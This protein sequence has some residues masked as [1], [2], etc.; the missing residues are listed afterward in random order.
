MKSN[1]NKELKI[2]YMSLN[3]NETKNLFQEYKT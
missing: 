1:F 3:H 2:M